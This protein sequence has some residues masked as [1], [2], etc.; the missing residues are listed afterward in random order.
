MTAAQIKGL[1]SGSLIAHE[2]DEGERVIGIVTRV[3]KRSG[4][5]FYRVSW[6]DS[7]GAHS[8]ETKSDLAS[9]RYSLVAELEVTRELPAVRV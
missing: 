5:F 4:Q 7:L 9:K 2:G 1:R 6:S 8:R 3:D